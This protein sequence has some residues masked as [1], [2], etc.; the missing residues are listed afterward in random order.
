MNIYLNNNNSLKD[1]KTHKASSK[2]RNKSNKNKKNKNIINKFDNNN[3]Y[4]TKDEKSLT[5]MMKDYKLFV[6]K[7]FG[8]TI[9]QVYYYQKEKY[10]KIIDP[11][12]K[13]QNIFLEDET[14][15]MDFEK[16]LKNNNDLYFED[17][18]IPI[19]KENQILFEQDEKLGKNKNNENDYAQR[20]K[21]LISEIDNYIEEK[22]NISAKKI[23]KLFR[24]KRHREKLY[25]GFDPTN[26]S[27]LKIYI[28]EYD[29]EEKIKSIEAFIYYLSPLNIK[30]DFIKGIKDILDVDSIS[31]DE[32]KTKMSDF[33]YKIMLLS[34]EG[35]VD[36]NDDDDDDSLTQKSKD[37]KDNDK[38]EDNRSNKSEKYD[39]F[40][41]EFLINNDKND[42]EKN[43]I[44]DKQ[45][46]K[47]NNEKENEEIKNKEINQKEKVNEE[48]KKLENKEE[49]NKNKNDSSLEDIDYENIK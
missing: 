16:L 25:L 23:Q 8:E 29:K 1:K 43:V 42:Y 12:K 45:D 38:N 27:F 47:I 44:N 33:L 31:K 7:Y 26:K 10:N 13:L 14:N 18:I 36:L 6:K 30:L 11:R 35:K 41:N 4:S 17:D 2:N 32:I 21:I 49:D 15:K 48:E 34:V 9:P 28:K 39:D 20:K 3:I 22:K 46:N 24:K 37:K 5:E 19:P 40:D